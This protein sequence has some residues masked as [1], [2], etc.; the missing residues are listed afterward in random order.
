MTYF[1]TIKGQPNASGWLEPL[2]EKPKVGDEI[3]VKPP[4][5]N[6]RCR[7]RVVALHTVT[8]GSNVGDGQIEVELV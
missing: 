6:Q 7:T 4:W 5:R 8:I 3:W 2:E 1:V